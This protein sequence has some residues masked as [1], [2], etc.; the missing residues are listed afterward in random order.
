MGR[1]TSGLPEAVFI[2]SQDI[3]PD[4]TQAIKALAEKRAGAD[5]KKG[6]TDTSVHRVRKLLFDNG[7]PSSTDGY[8]LYT[9][10]YFAHY[11][12]LSN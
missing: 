6:K 11:K 4:S 8:L 2:V 7:C 9:E 5:H 1:V 10:F 12:T 3:T